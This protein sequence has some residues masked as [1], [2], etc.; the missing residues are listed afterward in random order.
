MTKLSK[1]FIATSSFSELTIQKKN[2]AK[3]KKI[4]F[5]KNP[6]KKKLTSDQL[7]KYAKDCKYIIA[8]T[9]TYNQKSLDKLKKLEYLFRLGSGVDNVD[10]DYLK[11]K[12]IKFK[13]SKI[14]PE[15][16]VAELIVGYIFSIYRNLNE[17]NNNLKHKIWKKKMGYLFNGKTFGII[18]YGKVGKYLHKISKNFGVKI[19]VN[20]KRKINIEN[21]KITKLIKKSDIISININLSSKKKLLDKAKLKLCKKNCLIINTSRPEVID[22]EYLF[23]MLKTKKI[24]GA[25]LDVFMKEPYLGKFTHLDNVVLTPHIG[26]YCKEI[27]SKM[28]IEAINSIL[29]SKS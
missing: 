5:I 2:I 10:I 14:T 6:L 20:D 17:H 8:G 13:K 18:G 7:V 9:E 28:E 23:T 16:A 1:A 12:K 25:G 11:T 22:Y 21:T 15:V 19:L 4:L 26:S 24:M 3:K 29:K 27:R